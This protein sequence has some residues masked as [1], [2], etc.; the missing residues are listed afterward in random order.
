MSDR[1]ATG[2]TASG[3]HRAPAADRVVTG[4]PRQDDVM[5]YVGQD[6]DWLQIDLTPPRNGGMNG[7]ASA[8][9]EAMVPVE[10]TPID[11]TYDMRT[12]ARGK[13][14]DAASATLRH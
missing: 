14:P 3:R 2:A 5:G 8:R 10:N 6:G 13:D 12:D 7:N 11:I 4:Q 1:T 9:L